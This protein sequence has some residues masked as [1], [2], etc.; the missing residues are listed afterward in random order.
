MHKT[1]FLI[2]L[3]LFGC[4]NDFDLELEEL[5]SNLPV[6]SIKTENSLPIVTRDEYLSGSLEVFSEH[7]DHNLGISLSIRG[8][9]NSTWKFPKKSYQIKFS[10]KEEFLG[11]PKD[12]K[13]ILLANYSD[14]TLLRNE[15]AFKLSRLS[16]LDW[17]PESRFVELFVNDEY[18]GVYQATQKVEESSNRVDITNNGYLLEV[19]Q[20]VRVNASG[21]IYFKTD[22]YLF[23]IKEP[24]LELRDDQ[25]LLI[26][27][28]VQLTEQ[29][30]L[31]NN[32]M[33]SVEGYR[34]YIDVS[35]FVDWYLINEITK[36]NDSK[37]RYSVYLN[38]IPGGKLKMGPIWD[39]DISL[40]NINVNN[41][42]TPDGYWIKKSTWYSRLFE[43]PNFVAKVKS[44]F[45]YFYNNRD[46]FEENIVSTAYYLDQGQKRNFKKWPI[47]G[48]YVW[49]NHVAF[50]SYN[51]EVEYLKKWLNERFEWM[52]KSI[53]DL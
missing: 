39:Y 51:E 45:N 15:V 10:D 41:N 30:L 40:G 49:P 52:N 27:D 19:D 33:D 3:L 31:G 14:K 50:K 34:N 4:K 9:G 2:C 46:L 11:M 13:W 1:V 24:N 28:Y 53:N 17:T 6:I 29:V 26:R 7:V 48:E 5:T 47:L 35:S 18:L 25:F 42:E 23:K 37:F 38:Y 44:R 36:N 21:E 8:R 32:F 12:K 22:H 16:N 43:D 20:P